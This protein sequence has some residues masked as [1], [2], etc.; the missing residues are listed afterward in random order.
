MYKSLLE[1]VEGIKQNSSRTK[2]EELLLQQSD[3]QQ[4]INIMKFVYNPRIVTGIS[5]KKINKEFDISD[6]RTDISNLDQLLDFVVTNNTGQDS[7][8]KV[9]QKFISDLPEDEAQFVKDIIIKDLP[10]GISRTTLNKV[11]GP[12]FIPK[13]AVQ[14]GVGFKKGKTEKYLEGKDFTATLKLDGNRLTFFNHE[15]LDVEVKTRSGKEEEGLIEIAQ[16]I[17]NLPKG[18]AYD[19]EVVLHQPDVKYPGRGEDFDELQSIMRRKGLKTGVD[20]V[21][22]DMFPISEFES[23]NFTKPYKDRLEL[24]EKTLDETNQNNI[25]LVPILYRG[26]DTSKIEKLSFFIVSQGNEGIMIN[27]DDALYEKKRVKDLIKVKLFKTAD[28]RVTAIHEE[29]RGGKC[30]AV[31]IMWKGKEVNIPVL[32][33]KYQHQFWND[34][35]S[36]IGKI[37]EVKYFEETQQGSL[38]LP[39]FVRVRD[40]KTEE[41]YE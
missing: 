18:Y 12:T 23:D 35:D 17:S 27:V 22:F 37:I 20:L 19:G 9:I 1:I 11:Y 32:K 2:K 25:R 28:L 6:V 13:Y 21:I 10:I 15:A 4:F 33:Q 31:S 41:S 38:R 26:K 5:K 7:T 36:I 39:S 30:G 24:L 14:A 16:Q 34:P 40:D 29:V 8:V 3:N